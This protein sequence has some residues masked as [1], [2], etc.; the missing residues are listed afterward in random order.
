MKG[1]FV[2]LV[3]MT[4]G[5]GVGAVLRSNGNSS[6]LTPRRNKS[7]SVCV[8]SEVRFSERKLTLTGHTDFGPGITN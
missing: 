8:Q 5:S 1:F 4:A 2:L 3:A 7:R 6:F